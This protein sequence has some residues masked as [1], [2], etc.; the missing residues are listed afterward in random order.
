MDKISKNGFKNYDNVSSDDAH[1]N[2]KY[3]VKISELPEKGE[4]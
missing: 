4:F 1:T 2:V 3:A